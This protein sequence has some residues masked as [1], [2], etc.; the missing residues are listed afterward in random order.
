MNNIYKEM[1]IEEAKKRYYRLKSIFR[2]I[3]NHND[4]YDFRCPFNINNVQENHE[5]RDIE[6]ETIEENFFDYYFI[7]DGEYYALDISNNPDDFGLVDNYYHNIY[8]E[9]YHKL[10]YAELFHFRKCFDM[11]ELDDTMAFVYDRDKDKIIKLLGIRTCN[12]SF[13]DNK[14]VKTLAESNLTKILR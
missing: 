7:V 9:K 4:V 14:L 5:N 6:R 13:V 11:D 12:P 8:G 2:R 1:S 10:Y 3:V